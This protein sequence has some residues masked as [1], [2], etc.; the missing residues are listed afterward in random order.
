MPSTVLTGCARPGCR[1]VEHRLPSFDRRL[2]E[3]RLADLVNM[4][5]GIAPETMLERNIV[6]AVQPEQILRAARSAIP[7]LLSNLRSVSWRDGHWLDRCDGS[8]IG[9]LTR[10]AAPT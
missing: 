3:G 2:C 7:R 1:R 8:Y 10:G 4:C 6:G 9:A 5:S